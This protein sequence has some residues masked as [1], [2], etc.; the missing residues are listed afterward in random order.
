MAVLPAWA[1]HFL[2]QCTSLVFFGVTLGKRSRHPGVS[3][4]LL[5]VMAPSLEVLKVTLTNSADLGL[6]LRP[7]V[8]PALKEYIVEPLGKIDSL[9]WPQL[10]FL[11]SI[12]RSQCMLGALCSFIP[13]P[14]THVDEVLQ[15]SVG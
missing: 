12:I 6:F 4:P 15:V 1:I 3:P 11:S 9:D 14:P 8:L 7:L 13:I 5:D 2:R 10:E